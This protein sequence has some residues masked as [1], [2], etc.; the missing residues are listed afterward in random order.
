MIRGAR[1]VRWLPAAAAA[2]LAFGLGAVPAQAG[3]IYKFDKSFTGPPE[4]FTP[5]GVAVD[6]SG[7]LYVS[8][9]AHDVVD[10]LS[11]AGT[12]VCQITGAGESSTSTSECSKTAPGPGAF[13]SAFGS[14]LVE[15]GGGFL[16]P[17]FKNHTLDRFDATGA[18]VPPQLSVPNSGTPVQ[19]ALDGAGNI[20]VA[21]P[22]NHVVD[23][24][25]PAT[26]TWSAFAGL[27]EPGTLPPYASGVAVDTD[28]SSP[29]YGDVY[30][31]GHEA[32]FGYGVYVFNASGHLEKQIFSTPSGSFSRVGR[33]AVDPS[34]G[35]LFVS[36]TGKHVVDEFAPGGRFVSQI[37]VPASPSAA[38]P[39]AVAVDPV[40]GTLY[41]PDEANKL[42]DV[43]AASAVPNALAQPA[44]QI[45]E[46]AVTLNG[47]VDPDAAQGG[48]QIT[49]CSFE[50]VEAAHYEASAADPY[51]HGAS[52]SCSPQ[53]PY[54]GAQDVSANITGLTSDTVYH[55][56]VQA[57]NTNGSGYSEDATFA[58]A[59]PPSI[60]AE[61]SRVHGVAAE[62]T[63]QVNPYNFD[64][65][66]Q[67]QYVD[68]TGFQS[69]G[70]SG[71]MT[72][73]CAP[74]DLGSGYGDVHGGVTLRGLKVG[75]TYH[76]RFLAGNQSGSV[77]GADR[78]FVTFGI[79]EASFEVI[80][81]AG[82]PFTQAGGHPYE[83]R[84]A[85]GVNWTENVGGEPFKNGT[86]PSELPTGNL[87][88][89]L[90]DLPA[91]L[92]GNP[93]ATPKCTR[94][95][96]LK[97]RC[98]A[99]SQ[100][101][102]MKI[103]EA[104][105]AEFQDGIYNL[106]PPKGV[107]AEFGANIEQH[108]TVYID[109][110][111]RSGG[112]YGV[113][114]ESATNTAITGVTGV[115][116]Y[117]WGVPADPR[118]DGQ[119]CPQL[120]GNSETGFHCSEPHAA[121]VAE[122]QF[123]RNPTSCEGP[124]TVGLAAD[125]YQAL[126]VFDEHV[127]P[128]EAITGCETVPFAPSIVTA[129]TTDATDSPSGLS[130]DLH[131]PQPEGCKEEAGKSVCETGESDLKD[132]TVTFPAGLTVNPSSADGL[133]AC[134]EAQVGFNGFAELNKATE[135]G[136][137]TPQFTPLPAQ[138][139]DA[140]KLG[141]VEVDTPLLD[142]PLTGSIYLAKQ[143]ENPFGSLLAIYITIYD[144]VTGV[145]VKLPGEV[146]ADPATGQLTT[147][148]DQN[149]QV[150]FEDFKINLFEDPKRAALTTPA[151][152]G[153]FTTTSSMT[154]W[155]GS[156][157]VSPTSSFEVTSGAGG[158]SCPATATQEPFGPSFSAGTY[159]P[160]A[161]S[162]SPLVLRVG[163]EDGS[164]QLRSLN[165]TLP[166]GLLGKIA[167]IE[168]CPQAD[169]EAAQRRTALGDGR[170][171]QEDPSCPAGSEIGSVH[172]GVGSGAL[173]YVSGHAY[174]AGPYE[175]APYSVVVIT[176]AVAGP[177]DLGS[178]VVRSGLFIDPHTAQVTVR[179]DPFPTMLYGIPVDVRSIAVL[180]DR[181]QFTLNPTS[182]AKM[183]VNGTIVSTQGAQAGVSSPFQVGGCNNLPFKPSF[184]ASSGAA[185]S[186]K[187]G[188]SLTVHVALPAGQANIAK[189]H[190]DLPKQLPSRLDTL[191]LAC[192]EAVFAANPAACPEGSRVGIA[193]A[194]TPLLANPLSGP[195]Y[196]VSHG[197]AAFPD[198]EI[199]LQG[200]GVT[201]V[202]DGKTNI[203]GG[204]TESSFETV[205]DA[206]VESFT[207][208]LPAGPHS[209]LGAPGL[210]S[211]CGQKL[212]MPT[213][214]TAQNGLLLR[215]STPIAIAGCV[216]S[217]ALS[218]AQLLA[219]A[220]KQCRH[221]YKAARRHSRRVVCERAARKRYGPK[222]K[223]TRAAKKRK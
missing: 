122:K 187:D 165:V 214:L 7:D 46:D 24:Y 86:H 116:V 169:I 129:P 78:T 89:V 173:Y 94:A 145:V 110:R 132:T 108:V 123:L 67:V 112:D 221:R 92:I 48:G 121:G 195:A 180:A 139:P 37:A 158:G 128:L 167:G 98:S 190:V 70:Y 82:L 76:Y 162:Y 134:S 127:L 201:V 118:H 171:E 33:L 52:A 144:P 96:V 215:Q 124:L 68:E 149:P 4:S 166:P 183:A 21:D 181:A 186:R 148:V 64:T 69:S 40:S 218:R 16:F 44:T 140:S 150:P 109:A 39:G 19:V 152:C 154:P 91:G 43:Y 56:R 50:Y 8:D 59:G 102:V 205:P 193:T 14:G 200:E 20:Y 153:T 198:V 137:R 51:E 11:S 105:G 211:L 53:A 27:D 196:L 141:T 38:S 6:E 55:F 130:F 147:T 189:V 104:A 99:A 209:I 32:A 216:K 120:G 36:D 29:S 220:L 62:L 194:V 217:K 210:R 13:G 61:S 208:S 182:C 72:A 88:T 106:V 176:P 151:T 95:E 219:R 28:P 115:Q 63:A 117:L 174:L 135:P 79:H 90:N 163:R 73:P 131:L 100:V 103:T 45:Q 175:G 65:T 18:Y 17:D 9:S 54:G 30:L 172:V 71:A 3:L 178:V 75:T 207:L 87:R 42:I 213:I 60:D 58:T 146:K 23:R 188:A 49:Q 126:G 168:Q 133:G 191:K 47:H 10:K 179:S 204:I 101:G 41:V 142:H 84:T 160:I 119:R 185:V 177:F 202:L 155:S 159:S 35:H 223:H 138:C 77:T 81:E 107:A 1:G 203:K 80:D 12:Y 25:D 57:A 113:T 31:Q 157:A 143:G 114:A 74:E 156:S 125:S 5:T 15:P 222:A 184:A 93:S 164:Q 111:L 2:I 83:L 161:G 34:D 212:A 197:G 66:C 26:T 170:I 97:F 85:F 192:T 206:P 136:V 22:H 199:V